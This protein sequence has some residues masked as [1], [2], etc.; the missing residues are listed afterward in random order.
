MA[1]EINFAEAVEKRKTKVNELREMCAKMRELDADPDYDP[2]ENIQDEI[3]ECDP[4]LAS[5]I[6]READLY[7]QSF[8]GK[9]RED[10]W[11]IPGT[12]FEKKRDEKAIDKE[13]KIAKKIRE[14]MSKLGN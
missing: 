4:E 13:E 6:D 7:A 9:M 2:A 11:D 1:Q 12:E 8:C 10:G 3:R 5:L 14:K